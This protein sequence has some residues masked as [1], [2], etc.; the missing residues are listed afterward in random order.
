M[1]GGVPPFG[2]LPI[3]G[4]VATFLTALDR[5]MGIDPA[6]RRMAGSTLTS[7][8]QLADSGL[9][10]VTAAGRHRVVWCDPRVVEDYADVVAPRTTPEVDELVT[11]VR[12]R[13][14]EPLGR[15]LLHVVHRRGLRDPGLPEGGVV[16][17]LDQAEAT[18]PVRS[19]LDA[20]GDDDVDVAG[21]GDDPRPARVTLASE[22]D[23]TA[24]AAV[25]RRPTLMSDGVIDLGVLT[26]PDRRGE[27]W[28]AGATAQAARSVFA[29]G[30]LPLYRCE[31]SHRTS[32]RLA[33]RL[34][35][36]RAAELHV[37]RVT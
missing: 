26:H 7:S 17:D 21:F 3:D 31:A 9:V 23:G 4:V 32:V 5:T 24:V 22:P 14:A 36:R 11:Q 33:A 35:F 28:A 1:I 10:I 12:D 37:L 25:I 13:G 19:L 16:V 2:E 18:G 34:G 29:A 30:A 27:G 8:S 20:C 6:V 15:S